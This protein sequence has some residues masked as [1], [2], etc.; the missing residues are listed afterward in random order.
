M[1]NISKYRML[2]EDIFDV[3][4]TG[5]TEL[6]IVVNI[7]A[8]IKEIIKK[9]NAFNAS[10]QSEIQFSTIYIYDNGRTIE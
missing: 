10:Q 4:V 6:T 3:E 8:D 7:D 2:S 9:V 1:I 5:P